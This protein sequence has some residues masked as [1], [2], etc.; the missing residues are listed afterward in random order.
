MVTNLK[1]PLISNTLEIEHSYIHYLEANNISKKTVFLFIHGNPTSS[2]LWRNIMPRLQD[3][4]R[5]IALDL[6]GFGKSD[7]PDISYTFADHYHYVESFILKL[8]LENI[9]LVLHDWGGPIG[10]HFARNN[11]DKIRGVVMMET[12]LQPL[13]WKRFD[14]FTQLM[15]WQFRQPFLGWLWNAVFNFFLNVILPQSI[16]RKISPE[17]MQSYLLPFKKVI[18]R[19]P[20]VRFPQELPIKNSGSLNE[21][22]VMANLEWLRLSAQPKLL[23]HAEPGRLIKK[24]DV[25]EFEQ[26]IPLLRT[27]HIGKGLHYIQEDQPQ[28][29]ASAIRNWCNATFNKL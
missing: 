13:E 20:I 5:C 24:S 12:I 3:L 1:M 17:E 22:I 23:V 11:P 14:W 4:G 9:I 28:A 10:L 16:I 7:K 19:I 6:I 29:I 18:S 8:D 26:T 15:F 2:Y 27:A 25:I 21:K